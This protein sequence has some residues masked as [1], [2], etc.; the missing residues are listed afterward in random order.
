MYLIV[1][2]D[3]WFKYHYSGGNS[4]FNRGLILSNPESQRTTHI[5]G[6]SGSYGGYAVVSVEDTVKLKKKTQCIS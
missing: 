3:E 2:R 6:V 5:E 1:L 4:K